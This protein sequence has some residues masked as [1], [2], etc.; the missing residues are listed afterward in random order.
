MNMDKYD[1]VS[2]MKKGV[3]HFVISLDF[4]LFWGMFDKHTVLSYGERIIGVNTAIPKMLA[5]FSEY[6]IHATWATV[7]ML[8]VRN[9]DELIAYLPETSVQPRYEDESLSS[10]NYIKTA[11]I[12]T[13]ESD[14]PYH[15]GSSLVK[16]I[17]D[18]PHQ[19]I[20]NH[21]FSHFYCIDG[22]KN[23]P[24]IFAADLSAFNKIAETYNISATSMVFPRN[25][26][27][28]DSL[29][30]CA[31][32][33]ISA[34]RGNEDSFIYRARKDSKQ[35]LLIR[36]VRLLDHYFNLTGHHIYTLYG[37]KELP[38]NIPSS[39]FLRPWS[40]SLSFFE[41]LKI[42]RI[43]KAM[44]HAAKHNKIFHLWW[45]PH[46]FGIDQEE[47][48]KNLIKIL[49]HSKK[50]QEKYGMV[51]ASMSDVVKYASLSDA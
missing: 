15:F 23:K 48:F 24:E 26:T 12:G 42:R 27:N 44:T 20:G 28:K 3:G 10:Y 46:N 19:E 17:L 4:E 7:G 41:P 11:Q 18:T 31:E 33:G 30:V 2:N 21:T 13:N 43:K 6:K 14:D 35:S 51:S 1:I 34:Y 49:K 25:Q 22:V 50:L 8:M 37:N 5:L 39:R 47:N 32:K 29:R 36:G 9:K 40:N 45:H 16:K 38:I